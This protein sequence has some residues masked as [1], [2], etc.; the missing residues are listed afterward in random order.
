[1]EIRSLL[2]HLAQ[3]ETLADHAWDGWRITRVTGGWNNLLYRATNAEHDLAIKFTIRD[4]RD[5]AGREFAALTALRA[6]GLDLA[7]A[8][9]LLERD[10]YA[11]PVVAQTWV[12]GEANQ[13]P[14]ATDAEWLCLLEHLATIHT[15]TPARASH[16]LP[17]AVVTMRDATEGIARVRDQLALLPN[18][19]RPTSLVALLARFAHCEFPA[20]DKPRD[21]LCRV[22]PNITNFIRNVGKWLS[23]DWENSGWGDPAFEIADLIVHPAYLTVDEPRWDWVIAT[24]CRL[25]DDPQMEI[26][27]RAYRR[28]MLVWWVVRCARYLYDIPRGADRRLADRPKK[29]QADFQFKYERYLNLASQAML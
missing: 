14:P 9:V 29:W 26:R 12:A 25:R 17:V 24:Y 23:V 3:N 5:R 27:I 10:R 13:T 11:L 21:T 19:A 15:V 16:A 7:P 22:D 28:I 20:W 6:A 18:D 8:P 2:D 4:A 1:M